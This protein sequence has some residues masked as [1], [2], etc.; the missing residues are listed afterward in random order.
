MES[1]R[2]LIICLYEVKQPIQE[3]L[4]LQAQHLSVLLMKYDSA[5]TKMWCN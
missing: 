1:F 4:A 5:A 3:N 2:V